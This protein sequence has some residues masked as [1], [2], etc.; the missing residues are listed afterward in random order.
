MRISAQ[1]DTAAVIK[2]DREIRSL[3]GLR[4]VAA[5]FVVVFHESGNFTGNGPAETL[6]R[7]GYNAVDIF[8]VLSG[9]VMALTYG[10]TFSESFSVR[11]F[12][13]FLGRRVARLYPLYL[14]MTLATWTLFTL[15]LSG[16]HP[17]IGQ[18]LPANLLAI[19]AWGFGASILGPAWSI[20]AEWAAYFLFPILVVFAYS[21]RL[22]VL[23]FLGLASLGLLAALAY[24]PDFVFLGHQSVRM[25]PLDLNDT[26]SFTPVLRCIACFAIGMLAYRGHKYVSAVFAG[27]LSILLIGT[28]L[29]PT[30]DWF[31][32]VISAFLIAS[33]SEDKGFLAAL[34]KSSWI[35]NIGVWSFSI[36]MIH[37]RFNPIR[38][39]TEKLLLSVNFPLASQFAIVSTIGVLIFCAALTYR[40]I[41][42]PGRVLLGRLFAYRWAERVGPRRIA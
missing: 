2:R 28:M 42:K 32:V 14:L 18:S 40:Y 38:S 9:F 34:L 27:P 26:G 31:L 19:Q 36:Y 25:G 11:D 10:A 20:S 29:F 21:K 41:E 3:T 4:G 17:N 6:L 16:E 8:F 13:D 7:H 22:S 23:L 39:V 33:L 1:Y 12:L 35:Y 37:A 24:L 5:L 15:H 30:S